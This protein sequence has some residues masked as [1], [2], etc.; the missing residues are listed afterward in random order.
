MAKLIDI[1]TAITG[2]GL[3]ILVL[4]QQRGEGWGAL[5]GASGQNTFFQRRGLEK[6]VYQLTW[7][8]AGVFIVLS[9]IRLTV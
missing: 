1:I 8:L 5:F 3:I 9:I 7:I 4:L 6:W 2:I